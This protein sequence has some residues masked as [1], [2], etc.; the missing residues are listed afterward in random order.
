VN[1]ALANIGGRSPL[2]YFVG[3]LFFGPFVTLVLAA[4]RETADGGLQHVDL[5]KGNRG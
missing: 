1:A 5:W 3:S 2:Q 4:T